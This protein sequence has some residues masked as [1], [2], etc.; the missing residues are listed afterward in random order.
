MKVDTASR[1]VFSSHR[2]NTYLIE[3]RN[4]V[5]FNAGL[6]EAHSGG[7]IHRGYKMRIEVERFTKNG[8]GLRK[9]VEADI[10]IWGTRKMPIQSRLD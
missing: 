1:W 9:M 2:S 6:S 4:G 7:L 5:K 3:T 10:C 8:A